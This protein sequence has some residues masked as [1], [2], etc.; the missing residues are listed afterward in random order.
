MTKVFGFT[1]AAKPEL[2]DRLTKAFMHL[3]LQRPRGWRRAEPSLGTTAGWIIQR[4]TTPSGRL[5]TSPPHWTWTY[6]FSSWT[7]GTTTRPRILWRSSKAARRQA[8]P[9]RLHVGPGTHFSADSTQLEET[10]RWFDVHLKGEGLSS[11]TSAKVFV[12]PDA[13]WQELAEWPPP[14]TPDTWFLQP[15]GSL[16]REPSTGGSPTPYRYDPADPTP[17]LGGPS[18]RMDE[19]GPRD[20]RPLEA[21]DDVVTFTSPPLREEV[22]TV[23]R[24]HADLSLSSDVDYFDVYLRLC[25]VAPDGQSV[26]MCEV[27]QRLTP[28]V[29][30]RADDQTFSVAVDLRPVAYRFC[31]G[32]RIRLQVSRRRP[33]H[34]RSKHVQRRAGE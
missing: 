25:D 9:S 26:N 10:L 15:G 14:S 22:L 11:G 30:R 17:A 2:Q 33:P 28:E 7:S 20:N 12:L 34:V 32:H 4:Q 19:C 18:L 27:L 29:I 31:A 24:V 21:R 6:R 13:G 8:C 5:W 3:P 1:E 16:P 23:G